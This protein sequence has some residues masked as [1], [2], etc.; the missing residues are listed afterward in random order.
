METRLPCPVCLG[1]A[2]QKTT[3][4][5]VSTAVTLDVCPRCGGIWFERGEAR[6]LAR[7]SPESLWTQVP[8]RTAPV[9]PPCHGCGAPLD[10]DAERC[11]ACGQ[12]NVLRCPMCDLEMDRRTQGGIVLDV[13]RRCEGVWF[14]HAELTELWRLSA[15]AWSARAKE[16]GRG[17]AAAEVAGE[18]LL[19]TLFWAPDLVVHGAAAATHVA[20]A[21]VQSLGSLASSGA[22]AEAATHAIDAAGGVAEGVFSLIA[23]IIGGLFDG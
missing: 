17:G 22:A 15:L 9:R 14:D 2:M 12:R 18:A 21:A 4:R 3:A 23:D 11:A 10:R 7:Q 13:C 19:H 6:E 1:V 5:G 20:G 8:R 16:P